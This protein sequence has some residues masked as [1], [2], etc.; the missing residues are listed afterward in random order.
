MTEAEFLPLFDRYRSMVYGLALSYTRSPQDAEDVCQ[1]VFLKLME[2]PPAQ[3]K[4]K[5][6]LAQ[7]TVN[8]C[9]NL[10]TAAAVAVILTIG[11]L[12]ASGILSRT[13]Y[14]TGGQM[15]VRADNDLTHDV[16]VGGTPDNYSCFEFL[17][18]QDGSM[19]SV[20]GTYPDGYD[21]YH[22]P[23]WLIAYRQAQGFPEVNEVSEIVQP[24]DKT[25]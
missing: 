25:S 16:L 8:H 10:L 18:H 21:G 24:A 7:V 9:R 15:T 6:W 2:A 19:D 23:A 13:T 11:A 5:A 12:A 22:E 4:E 20:L 3:G 14:L 17:Y 1:S